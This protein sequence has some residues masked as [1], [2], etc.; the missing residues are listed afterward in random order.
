MAADES[1]SRSM[2]GSRHIVE[3]RKPHGKSSARPIPPHAVAKARPHTPK[4]PIGHAELIPVED[5]LAAG[6]KLRDKIPRTA[7]SEWKKGRLRE[8]PVKIL[9]ADDAGRMPELLPIRYG[10]MLQSPFTFYRGSAAIMAA[11]L[12]TTPNTGIRV[13]ACGDC[14]LLNFGG[15]ATPERNVIFDINDFDETLPGPWEW[16]IKRLVASFVLASRSAGHSE[17]QAKDAAR[18]AARSYRK[19]MHEFTEKHP[20]EVWYNRVTIN[21]V[22]GSVPKSRQQA[23]RER[24]DRAV[25]RAGSELDTPKLAHMVGGHMGIHDAPPL[26]FHPEITKSPE[27]WPLLEK[28]FADYRETLADDRRVLLDQYQVVD[29]AVKV[30]GIG[31]VGRRCWIVLLMS[32][33]NDTLF[34][35]FKEAAASV[36][37]P[38]AGK[39]IYNH[40]GQRVVTGQRLAQPASDAFLGWVTAEA[41]TG[42]FQ[43][44]VRQLRDA[45]IKPHIETYDAEIMAVYAKVCGRVLARAHAKTGD[46]FTISGYLGTS[47]QFDEAMGDFAVAYADQAER[48]HA[49]LRAAVK[50]GDIKVYQE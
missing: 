16:D 44:Y 20:R 46:Q 14:H 31:S 34:L 42:T 40:H 4:H 15:F 39:S 1:V 13:Q 7:Q 45:K 22:I 8:D 50:N 33:T 23:M 32:A 10:R 17:S 47:E 24:F 18:A 21:D 2:S 9:R 5:L 6:K 29:A 11:D 36:L 30:V 35:Q 12:A 19:T 49:A 48:D 37:E 28:V 43:F 25:T 3:L 27:F 26:I 41:S 38:Y